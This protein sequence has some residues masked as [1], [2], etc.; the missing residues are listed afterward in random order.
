MVV[1]RQNIQ[2]ASK[3]GYEQEIRIYRY[4]NLVNIGEHAI[5]RVIKANPNFQVTL[6]WE[7]GKGLSNSLIIDD[8]KSI[9]ELM[10]L[11]S[12]VL[13]NK[14]DIYFNSIFKLIRSHQIPKIEINK[15]IDQFRSA[16]E[17]TRLGVID[18][19]M[20]DGR[21]TGEKAYFYILKKI[22]QN[23]DIEAKKHEDRLASKPHGVLIWYIAY[24]Y[25]VDVHKLLMWFNRSIAHKNMYPPL[26]YRDNIC[27]F[28][29]DKSSIFTT[30]EH[31]FPE[32]GGNHHSILPKGWSC[33]NCQRK[34]GNKEEKL[35]DMLPFSM[36]KIH[37]VDYTRKGKFPKSKLGPIQI[38]KTRPNSLFVKSHVGKKSKFGMKEIGENQFRLKVQGKSDLKIISQVLMKA[39]LGGIALEKGRHFVLNEIFDDARKFATKGIGFNGYLLMEKHSNELTSNMTITYFDDSKIAIFFYFGVKFMI[40][41]VPDILPPPPIEIFEDVILYDLMGKEDDSRPSG[42]DWLVNSYLKQIKENPEDF[43]M[44]HNIGYLYFEKLKNFEEAKKA[45]L[46]SV[47]INYYQASG[48]YNLG[49]IYHEY[50]INFQEAEFCYRQ[51]LENNPEWISVWY[52][53][54][55]L[56]QDNLNDADKAMEAYEK[57]IE[58]DPEHYKSWTNLGILQKNKGDYEKAKKSYRKAIELNS[59]NYLA[60]NNLGLLFLDQNE[61]SMAEEQFRESIRVNSKYSDGYNNLAY[62]QYEKGDLESAEHVYRDGWRRNKSSLYLFHGY[63]KVL[64]EMKKYEELEKTFDRMMKINPDHTKQC[65]CPGVHF[66]KRNDFQSAE[67]Y[68]D[69]YLSVNPDKPLGYYNLGCLYSRNGDGQKS[70]D[71][72]T[73]AIKID[74]DMKET[75]RNDQDF[76]LI[77]NTQEFRELIK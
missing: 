54:G 50:L 37:T 53:L 9:E 38:E 8:R 29:L 41:L 23:N 22:L 32:S 44:W 12:S 42:Y 73:K 5:K 25:I 17:K 31:T 52:N 4:R 56:Y 16:Y 27:I 68:L 45:F 46:V 67:K 58:L 62:L 60:H 77:K 51:S 43:R 74:P 26:E 47:F 10:V 30:N 72:L 59:G 19:Q 2:E 48:W 15:M 76:E 13:D 7:R 24:N 69:E 64:E 75:A 35:L 14:S 49:K 3:A 33:D 61:I 55:K 20:N 57:C 66:L 21:L 34:F 6:S 18:L 39:A 1:L 63:A 11:M 65:I 40:S 28:C 71:F 70:L 36:L